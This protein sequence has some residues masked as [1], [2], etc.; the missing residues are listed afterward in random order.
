MRNLESVPKAIPRSALVLMLAGAFTLL[1]A[2]SMPGGDGNS[3]EERGAQLD[4]RVNNDHAEAG[5]VTVSLLNGEGNRRTLGEVSAGERRTFEVTGD[6]GTNVRQRLMAE[7]RRDETVVSP[8][9][10]VQE[11]SIVTWHIRENRVEIFVAQEKA[12]D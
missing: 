1:S 2:C 6:P 12:N 8:D 10:V 11:Q 4:I 9:I 5:R 7:S 3:T